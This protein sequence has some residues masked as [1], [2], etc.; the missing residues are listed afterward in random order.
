MKSKEG[1]IPLPEIKSSKVQVDLN[2]PSF[3]NQEQIGLNIDRLHL[4][5]RLGGIAHL[6]I[7]TDHN[8]DHPFSTPQIAGIDGQGTAVAG[9]ADKAVKY[10]TSQRE[11]TEN[12][13]LPGWVFWAP[14]TGKWADGLILIN[15]NLLAKQIV[16]RENVHKLDPWVKT[17]DRELRRN[18]V[19]MGI[20]HLVFNQSRWEN[21]YGAILYGVF[22]V[23]SSLNA[24]KIPESPTPIIQAMVAGSALFLPPLSLSIGWYYMGQQ[25]L[26]ADQG[27]HSHEGCRFSFFA[28]GPELDRALILKVLSSGQTLVK[29]LK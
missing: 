21:Y 26:S 6:R 12:H 8:N 19:A 28:Y 20:R 9:R 10:L 29:S 14:H 27:N 13:F 18:I 7:A 11:I 17:L 16:E 1:F 25:M 15:T 2:L 23:S 4:Y 3:L 22:A 5:C 24:L